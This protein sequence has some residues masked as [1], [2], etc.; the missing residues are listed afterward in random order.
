MKKILGALGIFGILL[1]GGCSTS[2]VKNATDE[3]FNENNHSLLSEEIKT[4]IQKD[5]DE[6][7]N[8]I[9]ESIELGEDLKL[10]ETKGYD[11]F[12][13]EIKDLQSKITY[14]ITDVK[15]KDKNNAQIFVD[16]KYVKAGELIVKGINDE[17]DR[18]VVN[19]FDKEN[20]NE[21]AFF[22]N[23][24]K[25][26]TT[27]LEN[28]TLKT[29]KSKGEL[30]L[31]KV[32]DKWT[33]VKVDESILNAL[34]LDFNYVKEKELYSKLDEVKENKKFLKI[35]NNLREVI[36]NAK[37]VIGEPLNKETFETKRNDILKS[38]KE[39]LGKTVSFEASTKQKDVYYISYDENV[40]EMK[41]ETTIDGQSFS[42]EEKADKK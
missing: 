28:T 41:V 3:F 38:T 8:K 30:T 24:F 9:S 15:V 37:A 5:N 1:V 13:K 40:N 39:K 16:L 25:E 10:K 14:E 19:H 17:L 31:K 42:I 26:I 12:Y 11:E 22:E 21:N 32:K 18:N 20:L 35:E 36:S 27:S 4:Q 2:E 7:L 29:K 33:I 6:I 23:V 34:S